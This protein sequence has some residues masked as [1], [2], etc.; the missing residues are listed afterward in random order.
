MQILDV[1][2]RRCHI[3]IGMAWIS[4]SIFALPQTIVYR[5]L[6]HPMMPEF[7]QC[8]TIG[9]FE[10]LLRRSH[11]DLNDTV[12]SDNSSEVNEAATNFNNSQSN[13]YFIMSPESATNLYSASFLF[14]VYI[15]PLSVIIVTSANIL[16]KLYRRSGIDK[17]FP[18][19]H[20]H[21]NNISH[22]SASA[23][24]ENERPPTYLIRCLTYFR[25]AVK[26]DRLQRNNANEHMTDIVEE[27]RS[28]RSFDT[29]TT[30]TDR[31]GETPR[32]LLSTD[33]RNSVV[34]ENSIN[35][36]DSQKR[37][38]KQ[39]D[40]EKKTKT[41]FELSNLST[42]E[43]CMKDED[44]ENRIRRSSYSLH[45]PKSQN[46]KTISPS[47][48]CRRNQS[49]RC[50]TSKTSS[51][52]IVAL[53]MCAIQVLAFIVCWTPYVSMSLW[54]MIGTLITIMFIYIK[55]CCIKVLLNFHMF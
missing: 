25:S 29:V 37:K 32:T 33:G 42:T 38:K 51:S 5:V 52:N 19:D 53:R 20:N 40:C 47:P 31:S 9:F 55:C 22:A 13:E 4:A 8:T 50:T 7:Q 6:P 12:V 16:N 28:L 3:M 15:L 10:N 36:N 24:L 23:V 27:H 46:Q 14:A 48:G 54:H 1:T 34:D 35:P 17:Q 2:K 41:T 26:Q 18:D 39:K 49:V 44:D 11:S 45:A 21:H 43:E 30:I